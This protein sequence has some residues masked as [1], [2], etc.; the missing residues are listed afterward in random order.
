MIKAKENGAEIIVC[1]PR[2]IETAKIATQYLPLRNGTNMALVNAFA[3]TLIDENLYDKDYVS[4]F[5]EGF[6]E[7]KKPFR[8]T[9]LRWF[10]ILPA[11][12]PHKSVRR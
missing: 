5:T 9:A 3:Y 6:E 4:R 2:K 1:D 11:F 7:Y 12:R 10:R 8:I